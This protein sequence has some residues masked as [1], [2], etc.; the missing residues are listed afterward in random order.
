MVAYQSWSPG[1]AIL[2]YLYGRQEGV[3]DEQQNKQADTGSVLFSSFGMICMRWLLVCVNGK[4]RTSMDIHKLR[5]LFPVTKHCIYLNNAGQT[6]LNNRV[7]QK[8]D[9]Y[10]EIAQCYPDKRPAGRTVIRTKLA[11]LFGGEAS[12]YALV[13]STGVGIGLVAAGINWNRGD[14][15]VIPQHEH[16]N[17]TYPWLNLQSRGV[18]VR[19]VP[20]EPD[21]SIDPE[22]IAARIDNKTRIV[23]VAAVRF[24][25]GFRTDCAAIG[26]HAH[27]AGALFVVDATQGAGAVPI[28]IEND[29]IDIMAC[30]GFKWLLGIHGTGFLYVKKRCMDSVFPALPGMFSARNVPHELEYFPD[31]RRFET[32]T[33]A[34][35]L[36]YAWSGGLDLLLD[37]GVAAVYKRILVLTD[38]L[39][40]GLKKKNMNLI[41]PVQNIKHRSAIVSFSAGDVDRNKALVRKLE[42]YNIVISLRGE[43]CRVSP[44]FFNTEEEIEQFLRVL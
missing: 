33:L 24:N 32:G 27:D 4:E 22:K 40:D 1:T 43:N 14:N 21:Y 39:I 31:A 37:I 28:N 35:A 13:T 3:T 6:P 34:Y 19:F 42:S 7:K 44:S 30:G 18:E 25:N 41:T 15:I 20:M 23:S 10:V 38:I 8:L 9:A 16:W 2:V 29:E 36:F 11:E 5:E 17:N 26:K 12:E